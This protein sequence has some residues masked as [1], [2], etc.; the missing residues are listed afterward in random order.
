MVADGKSKDMLAM[1]VCWK[2]MSWGSREAKSVSQEADFGIY[3][4]CDRI[5]LP[6]VIKMADYNIL[7]KLGVMQLPKGCRSDFSD[8]FG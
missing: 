6:Y 8:K 1:L 7:C 5:I 4:N 2:R 3:R